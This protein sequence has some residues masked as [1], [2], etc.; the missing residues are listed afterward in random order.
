MNGKEKRF[1]LPRAVGERWPSQPDSVDHFRHE[2]KPS[3]TARVEAITLSLSA[4]GGT[5][6]RDQFDFKDPE[7]LQPGH[8]ALYRMHVFKDDTR[9]S[10]IEIR[11]PNGDVS[12]SLEKKAFRAKE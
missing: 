5:S 10:L 7:V 4:A 9:Y 3:R 6:R 8:F 1:H 2:L 11:T 12:A